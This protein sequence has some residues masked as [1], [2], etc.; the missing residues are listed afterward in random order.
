MHRP[1]RHDRGGFTLPEV[2][3]SLVI[4]MVVLQCAYQ[5]NRLAERIQIQQQENRQAV[6][7][8]EGILAGADLSVPDGWETHTEIW[9][10]GEFLQ[11][12]EVTVIR[13]GHQWKFYYAG[14]QTK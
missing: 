13:N 7:L 12:T 11:G 2:L 10:E 4:L 9:R 1:V 14:E 8:A 6:T 5:W 3:V